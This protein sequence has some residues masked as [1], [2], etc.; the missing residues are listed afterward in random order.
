MLNINL[1]IMCVKEG[2]PK[3]P[4]IIYFHLYE[5]SRLGKS[6]ENKSRLVGRRKRGNWGDMAHD[7]W[8]ARV[9]FWS[10]E[11]ILKVT[12]VWT[13]MFSHLCVCTRAWT[14]TVMQWCFQRSSLQGQHLTGLFLCIHF[15]KYWTF[16]V[17]NWG[18][19]YI[20]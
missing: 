1:E 20:W 15:E 10:D 7:C 19:I 18:K 17:F 8:W 16:G 5:I 12:V 3:R 2:G 9:S 11:N 13:Q 14:H 4:N 6:V